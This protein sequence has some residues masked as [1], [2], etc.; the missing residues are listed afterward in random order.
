M[1]LLRIFTML[2]TDNYSLLPLDI[3]HDTDTQK[4]ITIELLEGHWPSDSELKMCFDEKG[5]CK[6]TVTVLSDR[7]K[8]ITKVT[9]NG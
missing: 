1:P 7:I 2:T 6:G 8:M 9:N 5:W 3:C 4:T